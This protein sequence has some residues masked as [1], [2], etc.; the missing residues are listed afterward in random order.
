MRDLLVLS[1]L[2]TS[3]QKLL[4]HLGSRSDITCHGKPAKVTI[5]SKNSFA[6]ALASI[7]VVHGIKNAN[8]VSLHMTMYM[9]LHPPEVGNSP[10]KSI[11]TTSKG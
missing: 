10:M 5:F 11:V 4:V 6:V 7:R 2:H 8:F 9:A 3:F 1:L